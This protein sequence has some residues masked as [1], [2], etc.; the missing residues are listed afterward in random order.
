MYTHKVLQIRWKE[1][2]MS[3]DL[4]RIWIKIER[5]PDHL[6]RKCDI[7]V[8]LHL[9]LWQLDQPELGMKSREYFLRD[10]SDKVSLKYY[11][12]MKLH[13]L[14][15]NDVLLYWVCVFNWGRGVF[16]LFLY[17]NTCMEC[18]SSLC[19]LEYIVF[20]VL[21]IFLLLKTE[22]T[23]AIISTLIIFFH[24]YISFTLVG[25]LVC[26]ITID[27]WQKILLSIIIV[28][29][30]SPFDQMCLCETTESNIE[31]NLFSSVVI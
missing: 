19:F 23:I 6:S 3:T 24:R 4:Q 11:I 9:A 21:L 5:N 20:F 27:K 8:M 13:F 30:L 1:S 7:K 25:N 26:S 16:A 31:L 17:C 14:K 29:N 18:A 12:A 2:R 10:K 15:L 28:R 22:L